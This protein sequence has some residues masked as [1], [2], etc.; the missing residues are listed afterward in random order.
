ML[1]ADQDD[2]ECARHYV[3]D[4]G[5]CEV[6]PSIRKS[7]GADGVFN[8]FLELLFQI[9]L[10]ICTETIKDGRPDSTLLVYVSGIL[11]FSAN[12]RDFLL[13]KQYCPYLSGLVYI[14]RLLLLEC[15]LP[16]Q[17]YKSIGILRRPLG[18]QSE[19][20]REIRRKYMVL[21]SQTPLGELLSFWNHGLSI[22]RACH[23]QE[24]IWQQGAASFF[25]DRTWF[26]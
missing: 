13:A 24:I 22:T 7:D 5:D 10:T 6:H 21:G 23:R 3:D 19:H 2:T 20:F 4:N 8:E 12:C 1:G 9:C 17:S 16:V 18:Q 25:A 26:D 14:Q 15:A 11:E